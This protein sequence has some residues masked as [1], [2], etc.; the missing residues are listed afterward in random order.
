MSEIKLTE[1]D[2]K[3][4]EVIK[5]SPGA[6]LIQTDIGMKLGKCYTQA[7]PYCNASLKRLMEA[8]EIVKITNGKV[9]YKIKQP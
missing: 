3:I 8:G 9:K 7:S 5:E 2:L 6:A 1:K 4:L